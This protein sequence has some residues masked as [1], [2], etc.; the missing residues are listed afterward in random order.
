MLRQVYIVKSNEFVYDR[1]FGKSVSKDEFLNI[2]KRIK[3]DLHLG[4][5]TIVGSYIYFKIRISYIL[6]K[7]LDLYIIVLTDLSDVLDDIKY[8]LKNLKKE[9]LN[10]FEDMLDGPLEPSLLE[11]LNP[12]V[13]SM[14]K[15]LRPKI[16]IVGFSGVGKTTTTK[17]IREEEIPMEHIPTITGIKSSI[18]IGKLLFHLWDF[19][20]QEQFSY[21][22]GNFVKGSDAV[23]LITDSTLENVEKSKFFVELVKD[24]APDAHMAVIGNK[25]DLSGALTIEKIE[26]IIGVRAYSMVAIEPRNREK[27]IRIISDILEINPDVSSLLKPLYERDLLIID[28]QNAFDRGDYEKALIYYEKISDLCLEL[29]EDSLGRKYYD[30][31][32]NLRK[33][34]KTKKPEI[35]EEPIIQETTPTEKI[36]QEPEIPEELKIFSVQKTIPTPSPPKKSEIPEEPKMPETSTEPTPPQEPEIPEEPKMPETLTEP[37][38]PQESEIPEESKTPEVS[39]LLLRYERDLLIT[40]AQNSYSRGEFNKA[41]SFYEKISDMCIELGDESLGKEFQERAEKIKRELST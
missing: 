40:D 31:A 38:P 3:E 33:K 26:E 16:S 25:Q 10:L 21:L 30:K 29:G 41:L 11:F 35:L 39:S 9:F 2:F 28:A 1:N 27:M 18:K 7:I 13:D 37:T 20:G 36:L 17:L 12:M 6:D 19:A 23:L 22:W 4:P 24:D 34:L 32:E 15:N 14:H 8:E 5:G